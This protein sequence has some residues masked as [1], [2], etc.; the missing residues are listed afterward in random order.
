MSDTQQAPAPVGVGKS[1]ATSE[2]REARRVDPDVV[3]ACWACDYEHERNSG[4]DEAWVVLLLAAAMHYERMTQALC[5]RHRAAFE[6]TQ[7]QK[8][9]GA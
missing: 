1:G 5:P 3:P 2:T 8:Q 6:Y 7:S 4:N 9:R